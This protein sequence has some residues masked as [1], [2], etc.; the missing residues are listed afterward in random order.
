MEKAQ[1]ANFIFIW[2]EQK[3]IMMKIWEET[4]GPVDPRGFAQQ[5]S[6]VD[7]MA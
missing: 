1:K 7:Y 5:Q 3:D 2:V 6:K 4:L